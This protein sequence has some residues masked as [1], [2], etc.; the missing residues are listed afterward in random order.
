MV[1]WGLGGVTEDCS[2]RGRG[3]EVRLRRCC[4]RSGSS[5]WLERG[6]CPSRSQTI[7]SHI[8]LA[9]ATKSQ[10]KIPP[11]T[12]HA[13]G[14]LRLEYDIVGTEGLAEGFAGSRE[15]DLGDLGEDI[16]GLKVEWGEKGLL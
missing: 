5:E 1:C 7:T 4:R 10:N 6:Q 8:A 14:H 13:E 2:E 12:I 3:P 16:I 15:R 9:C 11:Q